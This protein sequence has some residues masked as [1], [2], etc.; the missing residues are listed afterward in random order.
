MSSHTDV[1]AA[2]AARMVAGAEAGLPLPADL[3]HKNSVWVSPV[4]EADAWL[5]AAYWTAVTSRSAKSP[6]LARLAR[7]HLKRGADLT[8]WTS[9]FTSDNSEGN[10][11]AV[12]RTTWGQVASVAT[13]S[14]QIAKIWSLGEQ[15]IAEGKRIEKDVRPTATRVEAAL[16][17][18]ADAAR[19]A[20]DAARKARNVWLGFAGLSL[21]GAYLLY[22]VL[23]PPPLRVNRGSRKR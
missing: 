7:A 23:L 11:K 9:M 20:A 22:R 21:V 18:P 2:E 15:S 12:L 8:G 13:P 4:T 19:A 3:A 14:R 1:L 6:E 17:T 10:I 16:T 5:W